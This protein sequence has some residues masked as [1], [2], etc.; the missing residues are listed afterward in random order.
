MLTVIDLTLELQ[1]KQQHGVSKTNCCYLLA[2]RED[3]PVPL[4]NNQHCWLETA[5]VARRS[6]QE[7]LAFSHPISIHTTMQWASLKL[8][9][10]SYF[11]DAPF[12]MRQTCPRLQGPGSISHDP[13]QQVKAVEKRWFTS[14][15]DI[16][17]CLLIYKWVHTWLVNPQ[18]PF[19]LNKPPFVREEWECTSDNCPTSHPLWTVISPTNL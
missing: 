12:G 15:K 3:Q 13:E 10:P 1:C 16:I 19:P 14:F 17:G 5:K 4:Y 2:P 8:D 18:R 9:L 11:H 6:D 7:R